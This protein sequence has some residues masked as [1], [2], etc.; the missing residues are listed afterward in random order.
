[1][2]NLKKKQKRTM[3]DEH[4]SC[5]HTSLK[6][7]C[8]RNRVWMYNKKNSKKKKKKTVNCTILKDTL[9]FV[10]F[11]FF[12]LHFFCIFLCIEGSY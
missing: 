1:M 10:F 8:R 12:F 7:R 9:H 2:E 6:R 4:A 3:N 11:F 5:A